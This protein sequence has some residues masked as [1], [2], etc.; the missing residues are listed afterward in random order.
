MSENLDRQQHPSPSTQIEIALGDGDKDDHYESPIAAE[1]VAP[2][3][4]DTFAAPADEA[5]AKP[6]E[7]YARQSKP[8]LH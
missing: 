6:G 7:S 4:T 8:I 5:S 2:A 3:I 1:T